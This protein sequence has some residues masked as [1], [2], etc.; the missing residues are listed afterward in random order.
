MLI[1][2]SFRLKIISFLFLYL[3]CFVQFG[4]GQL[5]PNFKKYTAENGLPSSHVYTVIE[6]AKGFIWIATDQGVAKYDGYSFKY[7]TA[8]DGLPSD[9]VFNI[10]EDG[11]GRIWLST[12]NEI[13]YI[14]NDEYHSIEA[15][16][17]L[18]TKGIL[19][20]HIFRGEKQEAHYLMILKGKTWLKITDDSLSKIGFDPNLEDKYGNYVISNLRYLGQDKNDKSWFIHFSYGSACV[21]LSYLDENNNF[22]FF[23]EFET[24]NPNVT[25]NVECLPLSTTSEA[26]IV[27]A[28]QIYSFDYENIHELDLNLEIEKTIE[29]FHINKNQV[30][31]NEDRSYI[32]DVATNK[33]KEIVL[34]DENF[35]SI[36][37]DKNGNIWA[38]SFNGLF[39]QANSY[40]ELTY[41]FVNDSINYASITAI[42]KDRKGRIW[43]GTKD[44]RLFYRNPKG[45]YR[46]LIIEMT[47]RDFPNEILSISNHPIE[48]IVVSGNFGIMNISE[49]EIKTGLAKRIVKNKVVEPFSPTDTINALTLI[50]KNT[51]AYN[52]QVYI[53]S[54]RGFTTISGT[55][56]LSIMKTGKILKGDRVYALTA[57]K[58]K[59][60]LGKKS[61]LYKVDGEQEIFLNFS[62]PVSV[63][64]SDLSDNLWIGTEG[65]GVSVLRNDSIYHLPETSGK[66]V[67]AIDVGENSEA[68]ILTDT[69]ILKVEFYGKEEFN[70]SLRYSTIAEGL[71]IKSINKFLLSEG[72][73][74]LGTNTGLKILDTDLFKWETRGREVFFTELEINGKSVEIKDNYELNHTENCLKINYVSLEFNKPDEV[75]YE[76]KMEGLDTIWES[77]NSLK[78]EFWF[79]QPGVYTFSLRAGLNSQNI[80]ET[81]KIRFHIKTPWWQTPLALALFFLTFVLTMLYLVT[82]RSKRIIRKAKEKAK[83]E[84]QIS[85]MRLQA[86]QSQMNPHFIFNSLQAIQDYI[87]DKDEEQANRYLVKFSRLMRLILE[88]SRKKLVLLS[89]ELKLIELYVSLE[90]LRFSEQFSYQLSLSDNIN[91]ETLYVPSMLIQPFIE[92]AVNHGLFHKKDGHGLLELSI[93]KVNDSLNIIVADNGIGL[94]AAKEIKEKMR[95]KE[96]SRALEIVRERTGLYNKTMEEDIDLSIENRYDDEGKVAGTIVTLKLILPKKSKTIS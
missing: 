1:K 87:F 46:E 78:Q 48:G 73:L 75:N 51:F 58:D 40:R 17:N 6:D 56:P 92:N 81:K 53:G 10:T 21:I 29:A 45:V 35:T 28:Q 47:G 96:A 52:K 44:Q 65:N 34:P 19:T 85:D 20:H 25:S 43:F 5:H 63:L 27:S 61:G 90:Q 22:Y 33:I 55:S 62:Q 77:S 37:E 7:F 79:L 38:S 3:I 9:D 68:W 8:K 66:T 88:S 16:F 94:E 18:S 83:I 49:H 11:K 64:K 74:Y 15:P 80:S 82:E 71:Q 32:L 89:E 72:N 70:Y 4:Y 41:A 23:R 69:D 67:K 93:E 24:K 26:L 54:M 42:D 12:F 57:Y 13:G 50:V 31:I 14:F 36:I 2:R 60:Y 91:Q 30:V 76:Y 39:F 59:P 95:R 86:L 84:E